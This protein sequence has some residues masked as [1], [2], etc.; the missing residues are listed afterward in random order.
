MRKKTIDITRYSSAKID[1]DKFLEKYKG[2]WE[3]Y[4]EDD[5]YTLDNDDA[6]IEFILDHFQE[7][8]LHSLA[9]GAEMLNDFEIDIYV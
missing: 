9:I 7:E 6:I 2:E 1:V 4:Q 8:D 5:W 3:E